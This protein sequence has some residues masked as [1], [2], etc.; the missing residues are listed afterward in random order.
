MDGFSDNKISVSDYN[1]AGFQILRLHEL[2]NDCNRLSVK[3]FYDSW[4]F[5]LDRIWIELSADAKKK[6]EK[7]Y[8]EL[9]KYYDLKIE[10]SLKKNKR[11]EIY[12][13]LKNKEQ[14]LKQL[15]DDVGKGA[16]RSEHFEDIM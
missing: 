13:S 14:F 15:Q 7:K 4:R 1:E 2:W 11:D 5:K 16:K 12:S 9:L 8:S 10:I 3:G 6:N